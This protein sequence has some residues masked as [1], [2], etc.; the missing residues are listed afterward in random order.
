MKP[1]TCLS[2][3][4]DLD[5]AL[6]EEI[7]IKIRSKSKIGESALPRPNSMPVGLG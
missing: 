5:L 4:P 6:T 2:L 7:K 1:R 3:D